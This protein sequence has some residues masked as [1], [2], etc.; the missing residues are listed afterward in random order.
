MESLIKDHIVAH[1][2]RH[3]LISTYQFGFMPGRSWTTQLLYVLDHLTKYLDNDF[4]VEMI[5][6]DFQKAFNSVPHQCLM[7]KLSSFGIH[8]SIINWIKSFLSN[9]QQVVQNGRISCPVH[10]TSGVPLLFP[11]LVNNLP[12][13]LSSPIYIY[14]L[15]IQRF[16][17]L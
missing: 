2:N 15:T 8:S 6:L 16:F 14:L 12:S 1:V 7:Y 4:S 10:V 13:I 11:M 9:I 5:Y 3:N 17:M